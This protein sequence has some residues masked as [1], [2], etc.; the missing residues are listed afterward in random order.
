M[1][2][3]PIGGPTTPLL[4]VPDKTIKGSEAHASMEGTERRGMSTGPS[5][6]QGASFPQCFESFDVVTTWGNAGT[7]GG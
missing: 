4:T 1:S 3:A 5:G 6:L 7:D 2:T